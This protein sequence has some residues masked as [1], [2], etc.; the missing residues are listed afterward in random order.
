MASGTNMASGTQNMTTY[1]ARVVTGSDSAAS[2]AGA[3]LVSGAYKVNDSIRNTW[4][5]FDSG[6][7]ATSPQGIKYDQ[8]Y[9]KLQIFGS[10]TDSSAWTRMDNGNTYILGQV[11]IGYDPE[12]LD[13]EYK[14]YVNGDTT[15]TGTIYAD[16]GYLKSTLN[17]NTVTIGSQ[18]TD[19]CHFYNS[20]NIPFYFDKQVQAN[21]TFK[22]YNNNTLL[23]A[24]YLEL[25]G[26]TPY[27]DFHFNSTTDDYTSRIIENASGELY[28]S[29][30]LKI[31]TS[32][33]GYALNTA[34][35]ICDS[36]VRTK[37]S[38]GWF[39][40]DYSGGW[41]MTDSKWIRSYNN[42]PLFVDIGSN[43]TYGIGGHRLALGL[44]GDSHVSLMLKGGDTMYGFAVNADGNWYFGR[45]TSKSFEST[46]GD[47]YGYYGDNVS[48]LPYADNAKNL[49]SSGHRW[50]T[51]YAV[52]FY[53]YLKGD[54]SGNA[55]TATKLGTA[56]VGETNRGIY[57]NE[58][59]AT[60]VSWYYNSCSIGGGNTANYP[61]HRFA[62]CTTG[63]EAYQDRSVIV[64]LHARFNN[65]Q[66]GA[67]KLSVRTN[68]SGAA[69]D[70]SAV[71]LYRCG[72]AADAV[73]I[74]TGG[75]TGTDTRFNAWVKCGTWPR[76]IAYIL[77]GSNNG[78]SLISSNEPNDC[79]AASQ[80]T[81]INASVSG[82]DA[83]DG[84]T[85]SHANS[86]GSC[87]GN[88]ATASALKD[89]TNGTA[90]YLN[91]GRSG[92]TSASSFTW[93]C[94]WDG[95]NVE[96]AS[97]GAVMEAVRGSASG[98]WGIS[99]TGNA[100][101]ANY[102]NCVATN[103]IRYARN[104]NM[105]S[106]NS[107]WQ[108]YAFAEGKVAVIKD[109]RFGNGNG[110]LA[111]I[112]GSKVYNAVWNDY[113]E[114]RASDEIEP[115]LVVV[116]DISGKMQRS[117]TRLQ[118][119]AHIISDTYGHLIGESDDA[120]TPIGVSGRVL[121][122]PYQPRENYKIGDALCAAPNGTADIMTRE[123]ICE[124]PDRIIGIVSEIPEYE[125]WTQIF[126]DYKD[127]RDEKKVEQARAEIPVNGRIWVY[128]K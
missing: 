121:V 3:L 106:T 71:W 10:G 50:A 65:G 89:K 66:Y 98:S 24:G 63:T 74:T 9:N 23:G 114:C 126:S 52:N 76:M 84:A 2:P 21:S 33:N 58:G 59:T 93:L 111:P 51:C 39:N 37:G 41:Y 78:W 119:G 26:G 108:G 48:I 61:W 22:I 103:E 18:N 110:G 12:T 69:M 116:D 16:G 123:E 70:S 62:T 122:T 101:T 45:R 34:S 46:S 27:I 95:Y 32:T 104:G 90:S 40:E 4:L 87:T 17:S 79:T 44:N 20:A 11:G 120:K 38:T 31:A 6:S 82:K 15:A 49:G 88:A 73:K 99:I 109:W 125:M 77:E 67:V 28:V 7:S 53:G 30:K 54:I 127:I 42:K 81:E 35:F 107:L 75:T 47:G 80:G 94:V 96:P 124:Y 14:L 29:S 56:T 112:Y 128:V 91:Y 105:G 72:F 97:K 113:A 1:N 57:L 102:Q 100:A 64:I 115:G 13:N 8:T 118:A 5:F 25:S 117:T 43:N 92:I 19:Y 60:A 36:W 85:V 83:T 55:A 68:S 86:A